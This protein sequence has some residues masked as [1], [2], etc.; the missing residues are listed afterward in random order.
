MGNPFGFRSKLSTGVVSA[1]PGH[2][3]GRWEVGRKK[4]PATP[5]PLDPGNSGGPL[6][7]SRHR[8]VEINTAIITLAYGLGFPTPATTAR[9][10][11]GSWVNCSCTAASAGSP[12]EL[13]S[14]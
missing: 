7:D 6:V 13:V 14:L 8:V 4:R 10:V 5:A 2:A 3:L 12:S 9:W 1:G 11:V